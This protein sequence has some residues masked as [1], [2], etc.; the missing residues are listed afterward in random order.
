MDTGSGHA[1][2]HVAHYDDPLVA[3]ERD[4]GEVAREREYV[5]DAERRMLYRRFALARYVFAL[6]ATVTGVAFVASALSGIVVCLDAWGESEVN[7]LR[8]TE[9]GD[10]ARVEPVSYAL[11][12]GI[13]VLMTVLVV[14][15]AVAAVL[16]ARRGLYVPAWIV[17]AAV[18]AAGTALAVLALA[19]GADAVDQWLLTATICYAV[20]TA[21]SVFELWR[22]RWVLRELAARTASP[23]ST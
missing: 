16:H 9:G 21:A 5:E 7:L 17:L 11:F 2:P 23:R 8:M 20:M 15:V 13:T 12:A 14:G 18:F 6:L 19:A 10:P 3:S 4:A 1:H 22:A